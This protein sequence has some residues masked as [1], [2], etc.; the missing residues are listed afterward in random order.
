MSD[1]QSEDDSE[2]GLPTF[3]PFTRFL[4]FNFGIFI[5]KWGLPTFRAFTRLPWSFVTCRPC[6]SCTFFLMWRRSRKLKC[7]MTFSVPKR[8]TWLPALPELLFRK[9][10][11]G[12]FLFLA[13][14]P[15]VVTTAVLNQSLC[16]Q[17]TFVG[18]RVFTFL[19]GS[20]TY[21]CAHP[22]HTLV[23]ELI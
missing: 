2:A 7:R 4:I 5:Y 3:R 10:F 14:Y 8:K 16:R 12:D 15:I 13:I 17:C 1:N 18:G 23:T 6:T 9:T 21:T 19:W 11:I 22:F 20:Q